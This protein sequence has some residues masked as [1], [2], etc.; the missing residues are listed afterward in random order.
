MTYCILDTG[1]RDRNAPREKEDQ[2]PEI[3][4][5]FHKFMVHRLGQ[6]LIYTNKS[7]QALMD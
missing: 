1:F 4:A 2:N 3:A 6:K 7:I 5:A